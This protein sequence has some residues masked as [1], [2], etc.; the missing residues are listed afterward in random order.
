MSGNRRLI[1]KVAL[2]ATSLAALGMLSACG[3]S[4]GSQD[5]NGTTTVRLALDWTPNVNHTG[6]FAAKAEGYYADDKIKVDVLPFAQ[7]AADTLVAAGKA[8]CAITDPVTLATSING[9]AKEIAVMGIV[10]RNLAAL[11]TRA[12][13]GLTKPADLDGKKYGGFGT[14]GDKLQI[15]SLI[16]AGGGTGNYDYISLQDGALDALLAKKIDF[17]STYLNVEPL[18]ARERGVEVNIM[19]FTDFGVPDEPSVMLACNTDWLGKHADVAKRFIA[20]SAKGWDF[21]QKNPDQAVQLLIKANP[22]SFAGKDAAKV[23]TEGL[24]LMAKEGYIVPDGGGA[25]CLNVD[26]LKK[27]YDHYD[28]IGYWKAIKIP[29]PQMSSIATTDYLPASCQA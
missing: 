16:K 23:P 20:A 27:F 11:M 7:A 3:S 28:E 12:D 8:D 1:A 5:A 22:S 2:S 18:E 15:S 19:P 29:T 25:G 14:P 10:Q 21:T 9:G 4:G 13:S 6:F 17:V 26:E 24:E